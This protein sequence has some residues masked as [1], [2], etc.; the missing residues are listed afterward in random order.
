MRCGGD[1]NRVLFGNVERQSVTARMASKGISALVC[2][3][4]TL[5]VIPSFVHVLDVQLRELDGR[6]TAAVPSSS[7]H[8]GGTRGHARSDRQEDDEST[9]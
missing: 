6:E 9:I 7:T 3:E 1:N 2:I 4:S 5:S 8:L